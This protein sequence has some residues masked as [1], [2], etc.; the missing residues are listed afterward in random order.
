MK[1][2]FKNLPL[3]KVTLKAF[4]NEERDMLRV[5]KKRLPREKLF[6]NRLKTLGQRLV[7]CR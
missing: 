2:P 5:K 7:S 6:R 4:P 1:I 3:A